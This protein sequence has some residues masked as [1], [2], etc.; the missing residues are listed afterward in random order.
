MIKV[1]CPNCG[2]DKVNCNVDGVLENEDFVC[3]ECGKEFS[4]P[5]ADWET[6]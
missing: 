3:E 1:I 2:S 6:D 4:L 5:Q